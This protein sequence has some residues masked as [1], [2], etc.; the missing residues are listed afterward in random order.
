MNLFLSRHDFDKGFLSLIPQIINSTLCIYKEAAIKLLPTPAKSHYLF[1][2][3]DFSRIIGGV[4]LS[5]PV[6]AETPD[7]IR[8]LWTHEV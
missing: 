8:R 2:L 5:N 1:N 7:A 4:C 6:S 3:R